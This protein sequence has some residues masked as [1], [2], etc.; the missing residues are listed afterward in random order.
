MTSNNALMR[1]GGEGLQGQFAA[2]V[3]DDGISR[4]ITGVCSGEAVGVKLGGV[5][6]EQLQHLL[7]TRSQLRKR[8]GRG[9]V[10]TR[11]MRAAAVTIQEA[12]DLAEFNAVGLPYDRLLVVVVAKN[13]KSLVYA[14]DLA[15]RVDQ[16]P[17]LREPGVNL[18]QRQQVST[19]APRVPGRSD[20]PQRDR[21]LQTHLDRDDNL[22]G[23]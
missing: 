4:A 16:I 5:R 20:R 19:A 3:L 17:Q 18:Y 12:A 11:V 13:Q 2:Y 15:K 7:A 22:N 21:P 10:Q 6:E 14:A 9:R 23:S 8:L 1:G